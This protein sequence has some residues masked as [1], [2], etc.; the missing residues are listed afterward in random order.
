VSGVG[1]NTRPLLRN[2][3]NFHL[4]LITTVAANG[5]AGFTIIPRWASRIY[6]NW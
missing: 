1:D 2:P 4:P 3:T 5:Y 6:Y